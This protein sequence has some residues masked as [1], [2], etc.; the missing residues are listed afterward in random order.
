MRKIG[1][2]IIGAGRISQTVHI[3]G[4]QLCPGAAVV[5]V[6]GLREEQVRAVADRFQIPRAFCD[7]RA[8]LGLSEVEAVV[9]ATPPSSHY[10]VAMA[11]LNAGKHVLCEKPVARDSTQVEDMLRAAGKTGVRHMVAFTFRFSPAVRY[12]AD[13]A[14]EGHFGEIRHWRGSAFDDTQLDPE[15]IVTWRHRRAIAL[16]GVMGDKG[17]HLIDL[18]HWT[19]GSILAV[20]AFGSTLPRSGFSKGSTGDASVD[21][22]D[23]SVVI[24]RFGS[25]AL[26]LIEVSRV[27]AGRG[28]RGEAAYQ[29]VELSGTKGSAAYSVQNP[30]QLELCAGPIL[31]LSR[32][33]VSVKVPERY[34]RLEGSPRL[35][36]P[37]SPLDFRFDQAHEF[38]RAIQESRDASPNL[39]DGLASQRVLD[40]VTRS[41]ETHML[42]QV[43]NER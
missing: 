39:H 42:V 14:R 4:L 17:V 43:Q 20:G 15:A 25:G 9:I 2:G 12:L 36:S 31:S 26:G 27:V 35:V 30:Y 10:E 22:E 13:L 6:A 3:P 37:R 7:W 41:L 8:L 21:V 38:V 11:A 40:A 23:D 34:W 16:A 29:V 32:R 5:A 18:A 19:V 28:G 33:W 1:V 24:L